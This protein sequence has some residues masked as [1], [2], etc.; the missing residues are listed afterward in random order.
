MKK[1]WEIFLRADE[2][3]PN[4]Q[5][6]K[7]VCRTLKNLELHDLFFTVNLRIDK[8]DFEFARLLKKMNC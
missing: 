4:L 1:I 5:W 3:N 2:M 7:K 8:I 6:A